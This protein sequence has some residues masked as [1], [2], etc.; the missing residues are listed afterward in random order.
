MAAEQNQCCHEVV[1]T[2]DQHRVVSTS[3]LDICK[4]FAMIQMTL[5]SVDFGKATEILV[6]FQ[7]KSMLPWGGWGFR[8]TQSSCHIHARHIQG[9]AITQMMW[10]RIGKRINHYSATII[11]G[12]LDFVKTLG[13]R[14]AEPMPSWGGWGFRPT[15]SVNHIHARHVY[16]VF[17]HHS[18][19]VDMHMDPSSHCYYCYRHMCWPEF[20]KISWNPDPRY[21]DRIHATMRWSRLQMNTKW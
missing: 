19:D 15:L 21:L 3:I 8:P 5:A 20:W 9:F 7:T 18:N 10:M 11:F 4:V 6:I 14:W 13:G 2:F 12:G 16:K 1:E 17:G